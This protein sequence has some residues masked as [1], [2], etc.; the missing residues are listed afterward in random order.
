MNGLAKGAIVHPADRPRISR[1][2]GASTIQMVTPQ[3]GATA[4]L[5]GFTDIPPSAAIPLHFHNCEE[6]VLIVAGNATVEIDGVGHQA[7]EGDVTWLPA[8]VSHR[9]INPSDTHLLRIFWTY[10]S[11]QATRTHIATGV[12]VPI[13]SESD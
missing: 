9:F 5:N 4:F 6:S 7:S 2:G 11:I 3:I 10:S 13:M 1:Q 12:E 8:G